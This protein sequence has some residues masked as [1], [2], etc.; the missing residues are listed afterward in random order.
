MAPV[1]ALLLSL[2]LS[3]SLSLLRLLTW[4]LLARDGEVARRLN[5]MRRCGLLQLLLLLL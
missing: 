4:L 5:P 2:S 1:L 3:L